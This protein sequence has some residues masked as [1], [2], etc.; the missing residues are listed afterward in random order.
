MKLKIIKFKNLK[1][2]E[3][4]RITFFIISTF[5]D[6]FL[7]TGK[8]GRFRAALKDFCIGVKRDFVTF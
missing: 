8:S 1:V 2:L 3:G 5:Y 7:L 4:Y 6:F